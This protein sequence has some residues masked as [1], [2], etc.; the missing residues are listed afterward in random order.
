M[1]KTN[2]LLKFIIL[3]SAVSVLGACASNN[4]KKAEHARMNMTHHGEHSAEYET[5][6]NAVTQLSQ[7]KNFKVSLYCNESPIPMRKIHDWTI[8]IE[9]PDGQPVED[10]KV[11]IFGGMP[12]HNHEFATLPK[13]EEYLGNGKYRVEGLKF[14]MIGHWEMHFTIQQKKIR[15]RAIF[16][17]HM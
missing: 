14:N 5:E 12:M 4:L 13:V 11:F 1:Y 15:D 17:I 10:A 6:Q 16:K 8:H 3:L 7:N 9:T 2:A